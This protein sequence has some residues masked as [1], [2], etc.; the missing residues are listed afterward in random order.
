M[1]DAWGSVFRNNFGTKLISLLVAFILWIVVLGSHGVEV[2][3]EIAL[4]VVTPEELVPAGELP[5]KIAFRLSGPKAFLRAILDRREDPIRVNLKGAKAGAITYRFFSDN[6]RLPI[7][8]K[9]LSIT[10]PSIPI[11]LEPLRR[12]EVPVRLETRGAP[13]EG[14]RIV[15]ASVL[16]AEVRLKGAETRLSGL[17]EVATVPVDVSQLR[18]NYEAP[19]LLDLA[20]LG[21][22]VDGEAPRVRIE[23][24]PSSANFRL[25]NVEVR[26]VGI[27]TGAGAPRVTVEEKSVTIFVR[28]APEELGSINRSE[29]YAVVDLG[30]L[31]EARDR[32]QGRY[33]LPVEVRLPPGLALV[34]VV[35]DSVT[36]TVP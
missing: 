33:T 8:V 7:G 26:V 14:F 16:P 9:V 10:P 1:T 12:R 25:K 30:A 20:R 27:P 34:R 23:V 3:K 29:V 22:Q 36:V 15:R 5:E 17:T 24:E 6:I 32:K 11:R 4:E 35:P 2:T 13:P 19:V 28:A 18:R 31:G 21:V